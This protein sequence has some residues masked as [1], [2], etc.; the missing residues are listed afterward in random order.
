LSALL[1]S[2]FVIGSRTLALPAS[3]VCC[4]LIGMVHAAAVVF[5]LWI[6]WKAFVG[7]LCLI[8]DW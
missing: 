4:K 6:A 8:A 7:L 2:R 3:P 5:L 1:R